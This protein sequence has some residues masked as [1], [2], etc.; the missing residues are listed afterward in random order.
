MDNEYQRA[1]PQATD[2]N[3]NNV[4]HALV[5]V[6][7]NSE[8]NTKFITSMYD[9]ILVIVARLYP[10]VNLED[11]RNEDGLTP[12]TLATRTGKS[13]V[14]TDGLFTIH[15]YLHCPVNPW[16]TGLLLSPPQA[17]SG[18]SNLDL[19]F[20]PGRILKPVSSFGSFSPTS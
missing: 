11:N 3:G 15:I 12:L 20:C 5:V 13:G 14:N 6:A 17:A 18:G 16:I 4:L 2:Y 19:V 7:D 9:H 10:G 1:D 8:E